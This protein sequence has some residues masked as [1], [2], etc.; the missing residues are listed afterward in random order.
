MKKLLAMLLACVMVFGLCACSGNS[1]PAA[2]QAPA[3]EAPK[4]E[5]PATEAPAADGSKVTI[6]VMSFTDEVPGMITK[7]M[8]AHPDVAAKY[9]VNTTI[10]A[11]TDG[12]YQP[13]L[14]QALQ[15]GGADAP[16]IYCAESAFVLKYCQGDAAEFAAT[17]ED[18][19]IDVAA[20]TKA[21][22]IAQYTIDIG[23]RPSDGKLVGLGYQAT[24]GAFIYRRS[25]AKDVWGT[26]DPAVVAE[27]IGAGSGSWDKFF[28]AA[29]ELKAKGYTTVG[30]RVS[31]RYY[32]EKIYGAGE[33]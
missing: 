3:T 13:A 4:A 9:D 14:D 28:E 5:A 7:Y 33:E 15:A 8:E 19:G 26:D 31:R 2:T 23:T 11:T 30:G 1:A 27:K 6:N 32:Q 20:A 21:A 29:K 25:I 16:D 17:Y 22:D 18:L 24:G 10:I 12:L